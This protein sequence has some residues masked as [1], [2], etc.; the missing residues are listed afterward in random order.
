MNKNEITRLRKQIHDEIDRRKKINHY[1]DTA[2]ALLNTPSVP[3]DGYYAFVCEKCAPTFRY[4]GYFLD[5][6]DLETRAGQ[7]Y[8][9]RCSDL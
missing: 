9:G 6:E 3:R 8:E 4:Y 1:L 5:G 7:I 2:L